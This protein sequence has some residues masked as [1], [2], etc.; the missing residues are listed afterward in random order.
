ML[1]V[2]SPIFVV[3]SKITFVYNFVA[4]LRRGL[5]LWLLLLRKKSQGKVHCISANVFDPISITTL[6]PFELRANMRNHSSHTASLKIF[7]VTL[8]GRTLPQY[9]YLLTTLT[10]HNS[11]KAKS[12]NCNYTRLDHFLFKGA[13]KSCFTIYSLVWS[14][15]C[16]IRLYVGLH[17]LQFLLENKFFVF[18]CF[19]WIKALNYKC[20]SCCVILICSFVFT[21]Y[22]KEV[23][24]SWVTKS[25]YETELR[26]MTSLFELLTRSRKI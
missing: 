15:F 1:V 11:E 23:R 6:E 17:F 5:A 18:L 24:I 9:S 4:P 7:R 26:K 19:L 14:L 22:K 12:F 10:R 13:T 25:S 3:D 2:F 20:K 8:A 21:L 16:L